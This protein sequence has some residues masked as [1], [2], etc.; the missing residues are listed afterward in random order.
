MVDMVEVPTL[1]SSLQDMP[2]S[3]ASAGLCHSAV[4]TEDQRVFIVGSHKSK[5]PGANLHRTHYF[6]QPTPVKGIEASE[7]EIWTKLTTGYAHNVLTSNLGRTFAWGIN[8]GFAVGSSEAS[9]ASAVQLSALDGVVFDT[10][11]SGAYHNIGFSNTG[12]CWVW[13]QGSDYQLGRD[14]RSHDIPTKVPLDL[15]SGSRVRQIAA[16]WAH[17]LLLIEEA[18]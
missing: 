3:L 17:T 16:G 5:L 1:V 12:D 8:T 7:G 4:V 6:L 9:F 18:M 15:P 14:R 11:A 10:L 2:I 13:G